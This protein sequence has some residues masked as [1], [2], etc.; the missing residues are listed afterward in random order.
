MTDESITAVNNQLTSKPYN[1][2]PQEEHYKQLLAARGI[3][4]KPETDIPVFTMQKTNKQIQQ[5]SQF[6]SVNFASNINTIYTAPV[7]A[8]AVPASTKPAD[9]NFK[10]AT[11][12]TAGNIKADNQQHMDLSSALASNSGS[13]FSDNHEKYRQNE[14]ILEDDGLE[15]RRSNALA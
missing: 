6:G 4:T 10:N 5:S 13:Q 11:I 8:Q 14:I 3:T 15:V 7:I 12:H 9:I 1:Y 2:N